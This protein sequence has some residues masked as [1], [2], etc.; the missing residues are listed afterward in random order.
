M[1]SRAS[2]L[3]AFVLL[4]AIFFIFAKISNDFVQDFLAKIFILLGFLILYWTIKK[5]LKNIEKKN[6]KEESQK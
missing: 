4:S 1:N 2:K 3:I 5:V 6:Q